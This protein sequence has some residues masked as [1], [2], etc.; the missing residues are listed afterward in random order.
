MRTVIISTLGN[1][2]SKYAMTDILKIKMSKLDYSDLVDDAKL[3]T[4]HKDT[5]ISGVAKFSGI[6]VAI[7]DYMPLRMVALC[8]NKKV[9]ICDL[10]NGSMFKINKL[11]D[12]NMDGFHREY[13]MDFIGR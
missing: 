13:K 2:V 3:L 6:P 1:A 12:L 11:E 7:D 8:T 10:N 9:I 5:P 4:K